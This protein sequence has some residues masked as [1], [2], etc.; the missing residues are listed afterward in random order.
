MELM[1]LYSLMGQLE[2][3]KHIRLLNRMLGTIS[4]PGIM[5]L[6]IDDFFR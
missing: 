1:L 3:E 2:Q 6:I 4:N 5:K